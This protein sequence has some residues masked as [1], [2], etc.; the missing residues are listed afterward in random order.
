MSIRLQVVLDESEMEAIREDARRQGVTVSELV[1]R[2]L[3]D[4]RRQLASGEPSRKLAA[5]RAAARH[6]FP[7]GSIE[8]MLS[9]I[10]RGYE[11]S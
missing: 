9:E 8:Q 3:K 6:S 10:E 5:V 2:A 11:D 1:R 4:S 7:S